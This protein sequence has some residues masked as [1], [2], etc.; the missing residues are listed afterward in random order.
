M[1]K[2]EIVK[3]FINSIKEIAKKYPEIFIFALI[4]SGVF[5]YYY[6]VT[7]KNSEHV[8]VIE[9]YYADADKNIKD[10]LLNNK[11]IDSINLCKN[12]KTLFF[13]IDDLKQSKMYLA[14]KYQRFFI[15]CY[16]IGIFFIILT[17]VI[18]FV[19]TKK[20]WDHSSRER[21][22]LLLTC[23][24]YGLLLTTFPKLFDQ[25]KNYR[26]NFSD[27]TEF[28]KSQLFIFKKLS[29]YF[30]KKDNILINTDSV[31]LMN[32]MDTV[33]TVLMQHSNIDISLDTK[34]LEVKPIEYK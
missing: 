6:F 17:A 18:A 19:V 9:K 22:S 20:G 26:T 14:T 1:A 27:Y 16:T 13:Y 28:S 10:R 34:Q 29:P 32:A 23:T 12:L 31:S 7:D 24:F 33:T 11:R 15:V 2:S 3:S 21:K 8:V 5:F 30:D 25:E 4:T